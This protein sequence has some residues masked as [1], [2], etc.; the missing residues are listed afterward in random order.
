MT[1]T[2]TATGY[3]VLKAVRSRYGKQ[4]V[5]E[6]KVAKVTQSRPSMGTDEI[7]VKLSI[8]VP[9]AAFGPFAASAVI[10][11]PAELIAENNVEVEAQEPSPYD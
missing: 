10:D 6:A 8:R 11:V 3:V 4:E 9:I 7:A 2:V 5:R 1:D